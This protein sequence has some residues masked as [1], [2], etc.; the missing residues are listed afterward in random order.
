MAYVRFFIPLS[1][2]AEG[3]GFRGRNPGG[4]CILEIKG[5]E[6]RLTCK[7]QDL[8]PETLY[9]LWMLFADGSRYAGFPIGPLVVDAK[10][11]AESRYTLNSDVLKDSPFSPGDCA[12]VIIFKKSSQQVAVLCGYKR[13]PIQWRPGFYEWKKEAPPHVPEE[14]IETEPIIPSNITPE[15]LAEL[16]P[17]E[18][19]YK[20]I[21]IPEEQITLP[22]SIDF[23]GNLFAEKPQVFPFATQKRDARWVEVAPSDPIPLPENLQCLLESPFILSAFEK[24]GHLLLGFVE[25]EH[26]YIIGVPDIFSPESRAEARELGFMQFKCCDTTETGE[27]GYWLLFIK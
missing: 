20:D 7:A 3:F 24:F 27:F 10:G 9:T 19:H 5:A 6:G 25:D 17:I 8:K 21:D 12:A 18:T 16:V 23:P 13:E 2:E 1:V 15:E 14:L 22:V 26:Q 4:S 11:K